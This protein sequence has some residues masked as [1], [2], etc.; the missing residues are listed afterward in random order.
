MNI[1]IRVGAGLELG[2]GMTRLSVTL[3]EGAT[4]ADLMEY[5]HAQYPAAS[6]L[7]NAVL[8]SRGEHMSRSATLS[9]GQEVALLLPISGGGK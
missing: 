6:R 3:A 8:V 4:A 1:S 7:E 9:E 2:A 5:L